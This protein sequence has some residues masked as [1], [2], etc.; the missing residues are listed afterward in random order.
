MNPTRR[1]VARDNAAE[2]NDAVHSLPHSVSAKVVDT[3]IGSGSA[4]DVDADADTDV[5]ADADADADISEDGEEDVDVGDED[6]EVDDDSEEGRHYR[7]RAFLLPQHANR[8]YMM[9]MDLTKILGLRDSHFF[10]VKN[11]GIRRVLASREDKESLLAREMLAPSLRSRPLVIMTA[12]SAFKI[13][14]HRIVLGGRPVRDDYFCSGKT[15]Q[16]GPMGSPD[17]IITVGVCLWR[18]GTTTQVLSFR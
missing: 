13:F 4:V 7:I 1:T 5:D 16:T 6:V 15:E 17:T 14:G 2:A 8:L 10:Y 9:T 3:S 18:A 11:P 12:R